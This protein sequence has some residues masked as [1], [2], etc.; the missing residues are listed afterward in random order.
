MKAFW[1]RRGGLP[2]GPSRTIGELYPD[3]ALARQRQHGKRLFPFHVLLIWLALV[4][5]CVAVWG[6]VFCA[7]KAQR[8]DEPPK[9]RPTV[10][11]AVSVTPA[12]PPRPEKP[13]VEIRP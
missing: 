10:Y 6:F 5:F 12:P 3:L 4:L 13:S 7:I 1:Q 8:N 11:R 2:A 9:H